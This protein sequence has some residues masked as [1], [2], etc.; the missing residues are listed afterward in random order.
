M[1]SSFQVL[2]QALSPQ[3][4]ERLSENTFAIEDTRLVKQAIHIPDAF[5]R[6]GVHPGEHGDVD[7]IHVTVERVWNGRATRARFEVDRPI[8]SYVL[9]TQTSEGLERIDFPEVGESIVVSPPV[10]SVD[11]KPQP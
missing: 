6:S 4:I 5:N 7:D 11:L 8:G 3:R 1:P 10:H 9:L 2:G